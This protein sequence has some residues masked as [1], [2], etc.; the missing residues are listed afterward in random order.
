MKNSCFF[1]YVIFKKFLSTSLALKHEEIKDILN[2]NDGEERKL[3]RK[4]IPIILLMLLLSA[5]ALTYSSF[6]QP[7][8]ALTIRP[9]PTEL[10]SGFIYIRADGSVEPSNASI[11]RNGDVYTLTADLNGRGD[12]NGIVIEKDN[13][14]LD[15]A[16]YIL[17]MH[18]S[19]YI[20]HYN[21]SWGIVL[22]N[23]INVTVKD[24]RISDTNGIYISNCSQITITHCSLGSYPLLAAIVVFDSKNNT[25]VGNRLFSYES[26]GVYLE[27]SAYNLVKENNCRTLE[28]ENSTNNLVIGNNATYFDIYGLGYYRASFWNNTIFHNNFWNPVRIHTGYVLA[29]QNTTFDNGYPSG[30]NYYS[31]YNGTDY[32]SGPYQNMTGSDGI[33]DT[34]YILK[35][36]VLLGDT[37]QGDKYA[38]V[39]SVYSDKYPLMYS[40]PNPIVIPEFP[41]SMVLFLFVMLISIL[42]PFKEKLIKKYHK[43]TKKSSMERM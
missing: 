9:N 2:L 40:Y 34:P 15:S 33:G 39:D 28:L 1:L 26:S 29:F 11:L 36:T 16:G 30:G 3:I 20:S 21:D 19:E 12:R 37:P 8:K 42:L 24:L 31:D 25:F 41:S 43:N 14:I 27:H 38:Y 17:W 10:T 6:I 13:L 7:V 32:Y 4:I 18:G 35:I 22:V 23:R 5:T